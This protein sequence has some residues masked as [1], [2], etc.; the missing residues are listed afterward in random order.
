VW[1][2]F[3]CSVLW[4]WRFPP[5]PLSTY[6]ADSPEYRMPEAIISCLCPRGAYGRMGITRVSMTSFAMCAWTAGF[7]SRFRTPGALLTTGE[8]STIRNDL[9]APWMG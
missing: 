6:P 1:H 5:L 4:C 2:V 3:S 9:M 7:L 8:R